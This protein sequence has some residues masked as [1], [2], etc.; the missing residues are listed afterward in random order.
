M[1]PRAAAGR[2]W[3]PLAAVRA[4]NPRCGQRKLIPS[5]RADANGWGATGAARWG[6][7]APDGWTIRVVRFRMVGIRARDG[8]GDQVRC[9]LARRRGWRLGARSHRIARHDTQA[10][11]N[12]LSGL[13]TK[14]ST[15]AASALLPR[16]CALQI[17]CSA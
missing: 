4:T 6:R 12:E 16:P 13:S 17:Y 14:F 3:P 10:R 2:R 8:R 7:L 11:Y 1:L 5:R 15:A 9:V